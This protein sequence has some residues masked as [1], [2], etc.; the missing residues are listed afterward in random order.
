MTLPD[1]VDFPDV[2]G[3]VGADGDP[4]AAV[5]T[6]SPRSA[7]AVIRTGSMSVDAEP[8]AYKREHLGWKE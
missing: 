4:Q 3:S 6:K 2:G 8:E 7:A 5:T 1:L